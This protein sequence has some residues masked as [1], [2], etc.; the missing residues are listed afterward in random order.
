M[1]ST[2]F[3]TLVTILSF[4]KLAYSSGGC[5]AKSFECYG[6]C[7]DIGTICCEGYCCTSGEICLDGACKQDPKIPL[8]PTKSLDIPKATKITADKT[9]GTKSAQT[10]FP[11]NKGGFSV[12]L[13]TGTELLG[14]AT[15]L[16]DPK[17]TGTGNAGNGGS[18]GT[19]NGTFPSVVV[20]TGAGGGIFPVVSLAIAAAM[21]AIGVLIV[22]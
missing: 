1:K 5:G 18:N 3:I 6:Y 13:P 22:G 9:T 19:A 4:T 8:V 20:F 21:M 10:K 2:L 15:S 7:C 12:D 17:G 11:K 16:F 14:T